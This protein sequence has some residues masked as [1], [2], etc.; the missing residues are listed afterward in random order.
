MKL[1][2]AL[3]LTGIGGAF[4]LLVFLSIAPHNVDAYSTNY[5]RHNAGIAQ[6][7]IAPSS[8]QAS[9]EEDYPTWQGQHKFREAPKS[10]SGPL[11]IHLSNGIQ[12]DTRKTKG[13]PSLPPE[14]TGQ[15][16][17]DGE[18]SYYLVQFNGP[19]RQEWREGLEKA[20]AEIMFYLPDYAY[21]VRMTEAVRANIASS[22]SEVAWT[23]L[24]QP[25]YKVST[26]AAGRTKS[27]TARLSLMLFSPEDLADAVREVE[28]VLGRK[29][30]HKMETE[31]APGKWNRKIF[32]DVGPGEVN[33][34]AQ[35]RSVCWIEPMPR[36][37][38]HNDKTQVNIQNGTA[39]ASR[40]PVWDQGIQGE[41]QLIQNL[42][43]G[44]S[45]AS[46]YHRDP[47]RRKSTWYWDPNHVKVVGQQP[48]AREDE[49]SLGWAEGTMS[50][51]GDEAAESYHGTHTSGSNCGNDTLVT[52]TAYDGMAK[53]ARLV[54]LDGGGDS[55]SVFGTWDINR[56]GAW[57]WDSAYKYLGQR[58]YLSSNSWGSDDS[59]RY[60]NSSME[61]DQFMW[62]HKEYL[63]FFSNG[64]SY[65]STNPLL[66]KAGS[67]ATSKNAVSVGAVATA[68]TNGLGG[69]NTAASFTSRG[70]NED[71]RYSPTVCA[72]GVAIVSAD[73]DGS[74]TRSM[75]GTSMSC[76]IVAG[77]GALVRQYLTEGWYP[78]GA[79]IAANGFTPSGALIKA[80]LAISGDSTT[81]YNTS[82][83]PD[84]LF[85]YGRVNL[86][87]MLFFTG[88]QTKLLL[89]DNR[90]GLLTDDVLEY[91]VNVPVSA[92][93][94]KICLN[95]ADYPGVAASA[96]NI[97]NDLD[98]DA[99]DPSG[100]RYR[101]NR[102]TGT[103]AREST[104][105]PATND[106]I[107]VI[108]GIK[109][110][111]P[112]A[113]NWRIRITGKNVAAGPQPFALVV[114]WKAVAAHRGKVILDKATYGL[115]AAGNGDMVN[116]EV[117]DFNRTDASVTVNMA[118][119][120]TA[121][122]E[123]VT[124]D[125]I[126]KGLYR[127]SIQLYRGDMA[128]GDNRLTADQRDTVVAVYQDNSPTANDT[129]WAAVDGVSFTISNVGSADIM[130][131]DASTKF[132]TWNT[133]ENASSKIYYGTTTSLGSV[134]NPDTPYVKQH[135]IKMTGLLPGRLYYFDVESRDARGN[136]VRD[137]N[138]GRHYTFNTGSSTGNDVLVVVFND[139]LA[140]GDAYEFAHPDFLT[141][142]L[143]AGG[144][145]YDWITT[146]QGYFNT[147]K[148]KAYKA[149]YFQCG[150]ENY[151]SLMAWYRDTAAAYH[152]AGA[153]F[154]FTG[155][156]I[157]WDS[158]ANPDGRPAAKRAADTTFCRN[159]LHFT[160]KGDI[161]NEVIFN[162]IRGVSGDPISG[163]YTGGITYQ[164]FRNGACGD[165]ILLSGSGALG[166]GSYVW[167]GPAAA[168]SC[169]IKW[170]SAGTMGSLGNGVWGG[171]RTRVVFNSMEITQIDTVDKNSAIRADV[172]NKMF[173]WLIGHDHPDVLI[174]QPV[175]GNTYNSSPI[176][177]SWTTSVWGG[178]AVDT[179]WVEYS[180][181]A[182]TSWQQIAKSTAYGTT[183]SLNWDLTG[184]DNGIE[185]QVRVRVNDKTVYPSMR[186][187]DTVG[188]FTIN[189]P[190][191]DNT[192]PLVLPG[193]V[194]LNRNPVGTQSG[195]GFRVFATASD[196]STG[197]S[198]ISAAKC[199]VRVGTSSYV[200]NMVASDGAFNQVV[201]GVYGDIPSAGW[202]NGTY[203]VYVR[204]ADNS[205]AKAPRWGAWDSTLVTATGTI[206]TP[207]LAVS[208][209]YMSALVSGNSVVLSWRTE[210]ETNS[211]Q[212]LVE[213]SAGEAGPYAQI[214][215]LPAAGNSTGPRDYSFT[216]GSIPGPGNYW[217]RLVEVDLGGQRTVHGP[218]MVL[219]SDFRPLA[220]A[221]AP[222]APNPFSRQA[223]IRYQLPYKSSASLKVYNIMGQLV[224]TLADGVQDP[225]YYAVNWDGRNDRGRKL[226]AGIY[227]CKF[228]AEAVD[229]SQRFSKVRSLT[230]L[231]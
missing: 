176:N 132:I 153:R 63:W 5:G 187:Q 56:V 174:S 165:S 159:Y 110:R 144:W 72:P 116:I 135:N 69:A 71:G 33:A 98:L 32:V 11:K 8:N 213:R 178:A 182:G 154:S 49:V 41:G 143:N 226:A 79:K 196:S 50:K 167:H 76:P 92:T 150:Q 185:F 199:S 122:A 100:A 88:N 84:S 148:L 222:A 21:A 10:Y 22:K 155:H 219:A 54:F 30:W 75:D 112:A 109:R 198:P 186:G 106:S 126:G 9:V 101:G 212:W 107:N 2:S 34:L 81:S 18:H 31:W 228:S 192:G 85:G 46:E 6:S 134:F 215:S 214:G 133:S 203:K 191:G 208:M 77:A 156:D 209:A 94:L 205:A 57:G 103:G 161:V 218:V 160:Y 229:G 60:S 195:N 171:Y 61:A 24:F 172:L 12:F 19:V 26:P 4:L 157:G 169:A 130:P 80:L 163:D 102:Y 14:L 55:G 67:P 139:S 225:G 173:I 43:T 210:S 27:W 40:R 119:V 15:P 211:Y 147:A 152:N 64:N 113:G 164:P 35:L 227:V 53:N 91:L 82:F 17:K 136:T 128:S 175:A 184:V 216:D 120:V 87:T 201:E 230:L 142:A 200:Y 108:E 149:V 206:N 124:C 29:V 140:S 20:G 170:E 97:V 104:P 180:N 1:G 70:Y 217:Y 188:T 138:G 202:S 141:K 123:A 221:L 166:T 223:V 105:N 62:S 52:A 78:T 90:E 114:T 16:P 99:Y 42:D 86:D 95:W 204:V 151:P 111:T 168:D 146:K 37:K 127:G 25:A 131:P 48:A 47:S 115:P 73:G 189:R 96:R 44:C 181:D 190:G 183:G 177:I 93:Q 74:G 28:A 38:I 118:T 83:Y 59:G 179:T 194:R 45:E 197:L 58:A 145:T 66:S 7:G 137:N 162:S 121:D 68:G 36:H 13:E 158:W 23:G 65:S 89:M 220:F 39:T 125:S 224:K 129:A 51:W 117:H 3:K 193:S 231:K 207:G